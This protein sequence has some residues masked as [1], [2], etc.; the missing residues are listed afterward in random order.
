M[1]ILTGI[2]FIIIF[3][4]GLVV[5]LLLPLIVRKYFN[6]FLEYEKIIDDLELKISENEKKKK[7]NILIQDSILNNPNSNDIL[8]EWFNGKADDLD[9]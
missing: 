8:D 5:G 9:E 2:L 7:S 4:L 1:N 6:I 3:I